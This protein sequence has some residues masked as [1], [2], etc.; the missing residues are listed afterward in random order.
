[1]YT[2]YTL[3]TLQRYIYTI[4]ITCLSGVCSVPRYPLHT[5][6]KLQHTRDDVQS[7]FGLTFQ[8]PFPTLGFQFG[9]KMKQ[10]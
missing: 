2:R 4:V 6:V 5:R 1:M 7:P 10:V 3:Y 8:P 9:G